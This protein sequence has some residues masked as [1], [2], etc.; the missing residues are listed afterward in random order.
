[1]LYCKKSG[2]RNLG[3]SKED[4]DQRVI[5]EGFSQRISEDD[6]DDNFV[7]VQRRF[8]ER[9]AESFEEDL[10]ELRRKRRD[11][12]DHLFDL[13]DV[14]AEIKQAKHTLKNANS[15]FQKHATKFNNN[16]ESG[17]ESQ[18]LIERLEKVRKLKNIADNSEF[19]TADFIKKKI[20][21][22]KWSKFA[23]LENELPEYMGDM[24]KARI[25]DEV[26]TFGIPVTASK[27]DTNQKPNEKRR[28]K[29]RFVTK[30]KKSTNH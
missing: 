2:S 8:K 18:N 11:L 16:E 30:R 20:P 26:S 14:D 28:T 21:V 29:K 9:A 15:A 17:M 22:F 25:M 5:F 27:I 13:I 24:T 7:S 23:E 4:N 19:Q 10:A 1:M 12:E 3:G 6:M